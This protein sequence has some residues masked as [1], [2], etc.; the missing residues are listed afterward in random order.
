MEREDQLMP[1][2][3]FSVA[4]LGEIL[5]DLLPTG[6][7]LGGAPA[8]FAYHAHVLG[9]E[10]SVVSCVGDDEQ[11]REIVERL[12]RLGLD[13][14]YL[15]VSP[16]QRTG[17]VA[18]EL[19]DRGQPTFIIHE[20]VA[21]DAIPWTPELGRLAARVDA[22]CFGSLCQRS[23]P[24]RST[25]QHFLTCTRPECLRVFDINLRQAYFTEDVVRNSLEL[26]D[27]L[28]LNDDELPVVTRLLSLRGEGDDVLLNLLEG[29]GLQAVA[30][31]K[32]AAGSVLRTREER[33]EHPGFTVDV[34][35]TVGAGDAYTA[36]LILG[37][38][39]GRAI[40][41]INAMANRLGA[42]VCT[43]EGATPPVHP[44]VLAEN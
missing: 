14:A 15:A 30:L 33:S 35:D 25:V 36:A 39:E 27:V 23:A 38:L 34:V 11:G 29:F 26:A 7:K 20:G 22:V 41:S 24:S 44:N 42:H 19:N 18:V 2:R 16:G 21:W 1:T 8:N 5:W 43:G 10:S 28:K 4:G 40:P 9:L 6:R 13:V 32:G 17:T 37:L 3:R 12:A 31:T